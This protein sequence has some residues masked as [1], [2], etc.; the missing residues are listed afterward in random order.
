[1]I[2]NM[3]QQTPLSQI[4]RASARS[5]SRRQ[6][7]S[8]KF[9]SAKEEETVRWMVKSKNKDKDPAISIYKKTISAYNSTLILAMG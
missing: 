6:P 7:S 4:S 8:P 5:H 9:L 1:M 3:Q 2:R